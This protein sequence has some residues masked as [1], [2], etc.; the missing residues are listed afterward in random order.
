MEWVDDT[1]QNIRVRADRTKDIE[2]IGVVVDEE[3]SCGD[4]GPVEEVPLH[5]FGQSK[6]FISILSRRYVSDM[7]LVVVVI[8]VVPFF[9]L[10]VCFDLYIL[11]QNWGCR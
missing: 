10:Q 2:D 1:A 5:C 7:I 11:V 4:H 9:P 8:V 3:D 6:S